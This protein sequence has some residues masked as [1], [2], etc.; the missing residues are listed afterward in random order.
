MSRSHTPRPTRRGALALTAALTASITLAACG[1][2]DQ[3]QASG[4]TDGSEGPR[5][6]KVGVNPVPHGEILTHVKDE[7]A[8]DAGL[9]IEVVEFTDYVQPNEALDAG[10]LDANYFQHE[11][12]LAEQESSGGYDFTSLGAVHLEPLGL[13]SEQVEDAGE[14]SGDS[15]VAIPN[16]PS[17]AGRALELLA[18]HGVLELEDTG[19]E[20]ATPADVKDGGPEIVE[21]E[22]A[23]LPRS[24]GDVDAA[25][26]NGNYAIEADLSPT[27]DSLALEE[28]EGNPYAN[29]L[30]VRS[31]DEQ[32]EDLKKLAE[33]LTSGEVRSFIGKNY[34]GTVVPAE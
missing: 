24:L 16:D 20:L 11:P 17:N 26:I 4:G 19:D 1:G 21:L 33:L 29:L 34:E 6:L 23:Q 14:L 3:D 22:A 27:R 7:L 25:V 9:Q 13:Y 15:R 8:A 31:E 2:D 10:D 18:T 32:D 5:V 28:S 30:V 12:Y